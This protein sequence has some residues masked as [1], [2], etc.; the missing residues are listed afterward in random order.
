V[1][2]DD[3]VIIVG[4]GVAGVAIAHELHRCKLPF[5]LITSDLQ[6]SSHKNQ[7]WLHSGALYPAASVARDVWEEFRRAEP[8][9]KNH[10]VSGTGSAMFLAIHPETIEAR[11][12]MF[13]GLHASGFGWEALGPKDYSV[14]GSIGPTNANR[15]MRTR[16]LVVDFPSLIE[17][18]QRELPNQ[19]VLADAHVL[20]I[21]TSGSP[22]QVTAV[23]YQTTRGAVRIQCKRCVLA[24][25]AWTPT[26]LKE[27]DITLRR[28]IIRKQCLVIVFDEEL[29]PGITV[30]Y[31]IKHFDMTKGA[32]V[33]ADVSLVPY[34]KTTLAAGTGWLRLEDSVDPA[35]VSP[36]PDEEQELMLE[37][38]Q[39]FPGLAKCKRQAAHACI[40]TELE[41]SDGVPDVR[42]KVLGYDEHDVKGLFV[43][44]PGKATLMFD[45]ADKVLEAFKK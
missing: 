18:L 9:F 39:A 34:C 29:V 3:D 22:R 25:G 28:R 11:T 27:S 45:L 24:V 33:R 21:E 44:L 2:A 10:I 37:L 19:C 13:E 17:E 38:C 12:A 14:I 42:P 5:Q 16:D 7:K 1:T 20:R 23:H 36:T 4:G 32:F 8:K 26:L 15:G 40:K 43:A 31:D 6:G 30:C 35:T 41:T